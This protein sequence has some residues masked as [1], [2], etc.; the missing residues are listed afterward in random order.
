MPRK[1]NPASRKVRERDG[2]R[3]DRIEHKV[4]GFWQPLIY[5]MN[6]YIYICIYIYIKYAPI[7]YQLSTWIYVV[8]D[9]RDATSLMTSSW[10]SR[11]R[12]VGAQVTRKPHGAS[13]QHAKPCRLGLVDLCWFQVLI[14]SDH[15]QKLRCSQG[16]LVCF[17]FSNEVSRWVRAKETSNSLWLAFLLDVWCSRCLEA[18]KQIDDK[19]DAIVQEMC[20][21]RPE[22]SWWF[23]FAEVDHTLVLNYFG[24]A[25]PTMFGHSR[26][27]LWASFHLNGS[28]NLRSQGFR[29]SIPYQVWRG[30][31]SRDGK[32][33]VCFFF[34]SSLSCIHIHTHIHT[35]MHTYIHSNIL[36]YTF[37]VYWCIQIICITIS[38]S[39][40][41][42]LFGLAQ[43]IPLC[44]MFDKLWLALHHLKVDRTFTFW[45][46]EVT[47]PIWP[48]F[49]KL[50]IR[51]F[52]QQSVGFYLMQC[53]CNHW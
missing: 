1:K 45:I 12:I 30:N 8:N 41:P 42:W 40:P 38:P 37:N 17:N 29:R 51:N 13:V 49:E 35:Y 5:I 50:L 11:C 28:W 20:Y 16:V 47:I 32:P 24:L 34:K 22:T 31:L 36:V 10:P 15:W 4:T 9:H 26:S 21:A 53:D 6:I 25:S 19:F 39:E 18:I 43:R 2:E 52:G 33:V 48:H 27:R 46:P 23:A 7:L 3:E 44:Q 14:C